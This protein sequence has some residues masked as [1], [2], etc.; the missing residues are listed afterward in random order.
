MF[1]MI[2][3]VTLTLNFSSLNVECAISQEKMV[4]LL[5]NEKKTYQLN[6]RRQMWQ[7]ILTMAMTLVLNWLVSL[8]LAFVKP[9][10]SLM[11]WLVLNWL[12]YVFFFAFTKPR[13]F[14]C[15]ALASLRLLFLLCPQ[16]G[17]MVPIFSDYGNFDYTDLT[18]L[19]RTGNTDLPGVWVFD[20]DA[21]SW[22]RM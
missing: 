13:Y 6:I 14:W 7:L 5:Q 11:L 21:A 18:Y 19:T 4:R 16:L 22:T 8:F 3:V 2:W 12:I 9:R 17:F 15:K 10:H 20:I 1:G